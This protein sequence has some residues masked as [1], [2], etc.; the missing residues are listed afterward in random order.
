MDNGILLANRLGLPQRLV[1]LTFISL[2]TAVPDVAAA[3]CAVA[4]KQP[5]LALG[6]IVGANI[7]NLLLVV[8]IPSIVA[9]MEAEPALLRDAAA[10]CAAMLLLTVPPVF[11]GRTRRWQGVA[12]LLLLGGCLVINF[13]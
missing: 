7:I 3:L 12:L 9:P 1:A 11:T 5:T 2:G 13:I 8:G 10:A 6:N 4:R